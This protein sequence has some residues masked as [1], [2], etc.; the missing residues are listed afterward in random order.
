ME[1]SL[2]TDFYDEL[3]YHKV[4]Y[5]KQLIVQWNCCLRRGLSWLGAADAVAV[6]HRWSHRPL[7]TLPF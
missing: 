4:F 1:I 5:G 3:S 2:K 7:G 6:L